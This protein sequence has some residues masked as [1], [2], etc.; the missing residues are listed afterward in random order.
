MKPLIRS[1][2]CTHC[3]DVVPHKVYFIKRYE[4]YKQLT[5][6]EP[7]EETRV[8]YE[9]YCCTCR[10]PDEVDIVNEEWIVLLKNKNW[11]AK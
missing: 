1:L 9:Q 4:S 3:N 2:H 7:L 11:E 10:T 8:V 5:E 6:K